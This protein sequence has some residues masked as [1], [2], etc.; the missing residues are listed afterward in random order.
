MLAEESI[1]TM[2]SS[3]QDKKLQVDPDYVRPFP[4][5]NKQEG[6][7]YMKIDEL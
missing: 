5:R 1:F 3:S 2:L 6:T 7:L 4:P